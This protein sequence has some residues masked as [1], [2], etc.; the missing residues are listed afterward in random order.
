MDWRFQI[1][2]EKM[3]LKKPMQ[4]DKIGLHQEGG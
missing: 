3:G 4:A 1:K 2:E